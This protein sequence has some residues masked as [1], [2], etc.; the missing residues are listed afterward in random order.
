MSDRKRPTSSTGPHHPSRSRKL[1]EE[2]N[3]AAAQI[4]GDLPVGVGMGFDVDPWQSVMVTVHPSAPNFAA[5]ASPAWEITFRPWKYRE[6]ASGGARQP[7]GQWYAQEDW[8]VHLDGTGPMELAFFVGTAKKLYL[9]PLSWSNL[10]AGTPEVKLGAYG[11]ARYGDPDA[12]MT[13]SVSASVTVGPIDIENLFDLI[14]HEDYIYSNVRGNF[15]VQRTTATTLTLSNLGIPVSAEQIVAVSKKATGTAGWTTQYRGYDLLADYAPLTGVLTLGSM[16][17]LDTDKLIVYI[18]GPS[19]T[20]D[21]KNHSRRTTVINPD[22]QR[23]GTDARV[24]RV[25]AAGGQEGSFDSYFNM[26]EDGYHYLTAHFKITGTVEATLWASNDQE[27][28]D[29]AA[30][31]VNITQEVFGVAALTVATAEVQIPNSSINFRRCRWRVADGVD[32]A[33][34][35]ASIY[36]IKTAYGSP[37]NRMDVL[38]ATLATHNVAV[39]ATGPQV[40]E[41]AKTFDLSPLPNAVTEGFAVRGAATER[42]V[43]YAFLTTPDGSG[44]PIAT[45]GVAVTNVAAAVTALLGA[46]RSTTLL[47]PAVANLLATILATDEYG[48]TMLSSNELA[49]RS[50]RVGEV[51]PVENKAI[52]NDMVDDVNLAAATH[53]FPSALGV[54][55]LPSKDLSFTGKIIDA[56]GTIEIT[57]EGTND[58]D[59]A[60]GDWIPFTMSGTRTDLG[61]GLHASIT[62]TNGTVTFGMDFDNLNYDYWRVKI[63]CS[64]ATNTVI[65]KE[66]NKA[67]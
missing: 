42:G 23:V 18:E 29:P 28:Y 66:R 49:S 9:Q 51:R 20:L 60:A 67:L 62:V 11:I 63:V 53:Y 8:T 32:A 33:G 44:T 14:A 65:V 17:V 46:A 10:P 57:F 16:A 7:S 54:A 52:P 35:A 58:E 37:Q 59:L 3:L 50:D 5:G 27:P 24:E 22:A 2:F 48:R 55:T 56:D 64:G 4:P 19:K 45:E 12:P 15:Q 30:E 43:R 41:E 1:Q 6:A 40:M 31:Y 47:P 25:V 39:V 21:G 36:Y 13:G 61:T 34:G 38:V 26:S